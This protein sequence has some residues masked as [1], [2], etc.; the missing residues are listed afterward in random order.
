MPHDPLVS[1]VMPVYNGERYL[2]RSIESILAQSY[3]DFEFIIVDDGSTDFTKAILD[4]FADRRIRRL[5]N[6]VNFGVRRARNQGLTRAVGEFVAVQDADDIASADRLMNQLEFLKRNSGVTVV[7]SDYVE[8]HE[9]NSTKRIQMPKG[10]LQIK[11]H[12]LFQSPIANATAMFRRKPVLEMGGYSTQL[13][14]IHS[15]DYDLW[16]RLIRSHHR[17]VNLKKPL[18][19]VR[20][21]AS[22]LSKA[23]P[24]LQELTFRLIVRRNLQGLLPALTNDDCLTQLLWRLQVCGGFDEQL[25]QVEKALV[26]IEELVGSFCDYYQ[27]NSRQRRQVRLMEHRR[28]ARSLLHNAR[29]YS[30][31]G[32]TAEADEFARVAIS[33]DKRLA[34]SSGYRNLGI[35]RL[36]GRRTSN[37]LRDA[38]NR[39]KSA[40]NLS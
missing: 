39:L 28:T 27:L 31:A 20:C 34:F 25:E 37:R 12:G 16:S 24:E 22:G 21:A 19:Q 3:G 29:Q 13:P 15:E 5:Q 36:L 2:R 8:L 18:V 30:Y 7:G 38:R 14:G 33:L 40:T 23:K 6:S 4:S 17:L 10:D 35:K 11:W 1:V 32:R 9:E 26:V